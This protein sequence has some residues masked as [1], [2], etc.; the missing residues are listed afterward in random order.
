ML[1]EVVG[2]SSTNRIR[3]VNLRYSPPFV[4]YTDEQ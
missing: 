4:N 2:S 3:I 1:R